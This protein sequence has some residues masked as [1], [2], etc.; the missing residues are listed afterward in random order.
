MR[1]LKINVPGFIL[2]SSPD[3]ENHEE[4]GLK[5]AS[6]PKSRN[7]KMTQ[8]LP[9]SSSRNEIKRRWS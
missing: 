2:L 1:S 5:F 7:R 3:F 8:R 9:A 6:K 4:E